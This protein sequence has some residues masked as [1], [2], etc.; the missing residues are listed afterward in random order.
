MERIFGDRPQ[1]D[2]RIFDDAAQ[3]LY[4]EATGTRFITM[5]EL[6]IFL[7]KCEGRADEFQVCENIVEDGELI[8]DVL[9]HRRA[10]LTEDNEL[11]IA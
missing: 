10:W 9:G 6:L 11:N 2:E 7:K 8:R 3:Y 1:E 4:H 5:M